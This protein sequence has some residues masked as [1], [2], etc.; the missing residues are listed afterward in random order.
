MSDFNPS[1]DINN[2][3]QWNSRQFTEYFDKGGDLKP[4]YESAVRILQ[5]ASDPETKKK[6]VQSL[7]EASTTA[8]KEINMKK[9][10]QKA[11]SESAHA[12]IGNVFGKYLSTGLYLQKTD[13][14]IKQI[15]KAI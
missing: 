11:S 15:E 2:F 4:I 9:M 3:D 12:K 13:D 14:L 5:K 10:Q 1:L 7:K 6:I 8:K